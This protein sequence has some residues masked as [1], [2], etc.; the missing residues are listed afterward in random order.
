MVVVEMSKVILTHAV[1]WSV[2]DVRVT[3]FYYVEGA[4]MR[5]QVT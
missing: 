5:V 2:D 4:H 3:D 1:M